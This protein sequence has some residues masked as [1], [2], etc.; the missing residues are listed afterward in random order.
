MNIVHSVWTLTVLDVN[1]TMYIL[2][3]LKRNN[4]GNNLII[5]TI[6]KKEL[7]KSKDYDKQGNQI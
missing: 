5:L 1:I 4:Y 2:E 6:D 3:T 7:I